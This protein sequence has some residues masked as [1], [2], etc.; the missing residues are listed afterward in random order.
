MIMDFV[1]GVPSACSALLQSM[2][3]FG[4]S[5]ETAFSG[6][7]GGHLDQ[8]ADLRVQ[9]VISAVCVQGKGRVSLW[10]PQ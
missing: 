10:R 5:F 3:D 1:Q 8:G 6:P 9:G 7:P 2:V 4:S